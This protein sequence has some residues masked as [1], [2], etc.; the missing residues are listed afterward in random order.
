MQCFL[1][2]ESVFLNLHQIYNQQVWMG[3]LQIVETCHALNVS[4][5]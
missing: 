1:Y 4:V 2:F 5:I 3:A